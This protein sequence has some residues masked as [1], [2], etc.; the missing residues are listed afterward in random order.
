MDNKIVMFGHGGS[1]N[2]GCEAIVRSTMTILRDVKPDVH[3]YTNSVASDTEFGLDKLVTLHQQRTPLNKY[4]PMHLFAMGMKKVFH[5]DTAYLNTFFNGKMED[6]KNSLCMSIGGDMYCYGKLSWLYYIHEKLKSNGNKTVLWGCS[7]DDGSFFD[8]SVQDL[9][10]YDLIVTRESV[11][12]N[13]LIKHGM[14]NVLLHP[15]PAFCLEKQDSG[16]RVEQGIAINISPLMDRYKQGASLSEN[17]HRLIRHILRDTQFKIIF[18]PHVNGSAYAEDDYTYLKQYC[19]AYADTGRVV[20]L[21]RKYNCSQLKD[22]ISQCRFLI[23]ARTHASIA[24]YSTCVPTAVLGYS[25]KS[26]GIARDIFG[27]DKNYVVP[28]KNLKSEDELVNAF[29]WLC[30]N[31][32]SIKKELKEK[33]PAYID[34]SRAAAGCLDKRS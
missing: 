6:V 12:Y 8:E 2:H 28:V 24:A 9:R 34:R 30:E 16:Y 14:K 5:N 21:E 23:T 33:M 7:V 11:S 15:D 4:N 17:V 19:D 10:R 32:Q 25:V 22:I 1:Y 20:L 29:D 26:I 31:E 27:T 3:L 18:I 13:L